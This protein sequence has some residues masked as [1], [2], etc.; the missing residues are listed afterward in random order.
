MNKLAKEGLALVLLGAAYLSSYSFNYSSRDS[1]KSQAEIY[2]KVL[3]DVSKR[4]DGFGVL[5]LAI[6]GFTSAY[7]L[8]KPLGLKHK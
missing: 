6:A 4:D 1:L 3:S 8:R 2:T 5:E 7:I